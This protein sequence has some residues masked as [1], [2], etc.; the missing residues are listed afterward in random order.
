V[1]GEEE[2]RG[3][4]PVDSEEEEGKDDDVETGGVSG[5]PAV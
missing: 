2:F 1:F 5:N 3:G 4:V